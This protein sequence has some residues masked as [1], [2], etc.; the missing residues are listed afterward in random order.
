MMPTTDS[1]GLAA[2][3]LTERIE[4]ADKAAAWDKAD[5]AARP[6]AA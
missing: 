3:M 6:T 1:D 5:G 2:A 4:V